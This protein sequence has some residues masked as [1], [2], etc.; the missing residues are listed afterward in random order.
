MRRSFKR[1]KVTSG[2]RRRAISSSVLKFPKDKKTTTKLEKSR[3]LR[4]LSASKT[5]RAGRSDQRTYLT[6]GE[7]GR[8][9]MEIT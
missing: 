1:E 4:E 8:S 2:R 9:K 7:A 5:A 6:K 3:I